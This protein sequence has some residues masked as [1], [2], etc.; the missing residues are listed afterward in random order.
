MKEQVMRH[1]ID[2]DNSVHKLGELIDIVKKAA[3]NKMK[4]ISIGTCTYR[5]ICTSLLSRT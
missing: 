5:G 3:A 4:N 2:N 1:N